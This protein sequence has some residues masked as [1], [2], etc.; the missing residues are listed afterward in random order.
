MKRD[1]S[2]Y[3]DVSWLVA[4]ALTAGALGIVLAFLIKGLASDPGHP[5]PGEWLQSAANILG[6]AISGGVAAFVALW[7]LSRE[8]REREKARR[9]ILTSTINAIDGWIEQLVE[10]IERETV[11]I[12]RHFP[13]N[14]QNLIVAALNVLRGLRIPEALQIQIAQTHPRLFREVLGISEIIDRFTQPLE[15]SGKV[16]MVKRTGGVGQGFITPL[17][18]DDARSIAIL[19]DQFAISLLIC[20][21]IE[22]TLAARCHAAAQRLFRTTDVSIEVALSEHGIVF[23]SEHL[24]SRPPWYAST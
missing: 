18:Q 6:A 20:G 10:R 8:Q 13:R 7:I 23:D 22:P 19:P 3:A 9:A 17:N 5:T 1:R 14:D 15:R 11:E 16:G 12:V 2:L 24:A 21:D 4:I